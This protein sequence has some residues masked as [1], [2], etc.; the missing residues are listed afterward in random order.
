MRLKFLLKKIL[1]ATL[2]ILTLFNFI[3][4]T[5]VRSNLSFADVDDSTT[6]AMAVSENANNKTLDLIEGAASGIATLVTLGIKMLIMGLV[7]AIQGIITAL[8]ASA[9]VNE[10][11]TGFI[12]PFDIFFNKFKLVDI[13]IFS[14]SGL[15]TD[16]LVYKIRTRTSMWYYIFRAIALVI[17]AIML[18]INLVK[19]LSKNVSSDQKANAKNS[20]ID[21]LTSLVLV[22]FMHIIVIAIINLNNV[23]VDMIKNIFNTSLASTGLSDIMDAILDT[24]FSWN[25]ILSW[26]SVA[27]YAIMVFQ[28]GR[29]LLVYI[30]RFLIVELLVIIS[31]FI[32]ITYSYDKMK[33]GTGK[34]LN[35]WISEMIYNV[36][37]QL[38]H[39]IIYAVMVG[40]AMESLSSSSGIGSL[41]DLAPAVM[42]IATMFFIKQAEKML[43]SIF[44][45]DKAQSIT[46][47]VFENSFNSVR[48]AV[49]TI[50]RFS[51]AGA[52][53]A[54]G[55]GLPFGQNIA[56]T[57]RANGG[58]EGTSRLG[59]FVNNIRA[60]RNAGAQMRNIRN[61]AGNDALN[62]EFE[63]IQGDRSSSSN[64]N[65]SRALSSASEQSLSGDSSSSG[66]ARETAVAAGGGFLGGMMVGG[67]GSL[68]EK[69]DEK[70]RKI[71]DTI[72]STKTK[73]T[74]HTHEKEEVEKPVQAD[75]YEDISNKEIL[76]DFRIKFQNIENQAKDIENEF[77]AERENKSNELIANLQ[78]RGQSL[79]PDVIKDIQA[80]IDGES[81]PNKINAYINNLGDTPERRYADFYNTLKQNDEFSSELQEQKKALISEYKAKGI[82]I[83]SEMEKKL[84]SSNSE[85]AFDDLAKK[86]TEKFV[87]E[88]EPTIT[89]V[90]SPETEESVDLAEIVRDIPQVR[91][92]AV[93]T[94]ARI[95]QIH[96][97][98]E[99]DGSINEETIT[100]ITIETSKALSTNQFSSSNIESAKAALEKEGDEAVRAFKEYSENPNEFTAKA[101]SNAGRELA[102][103][104]TRAQFAGFMVTQAQ[105]IQ[106]ESSSYEAQ[107]TKTS[108]VT[109]GVLNDLNRRRGG[110]NGIID[111][112]AAIEARNRNRNNNSNR[113][114]A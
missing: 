19:A 46:N 62:A 71:Q 41:G 109:S 14:T 99:I 72:D 64:L 89:V 69:V 38:L 11:L 30:K 43:K 80:V 73:E 105:T 21:W 13:N 34:A 24:C 66:S 2:I 83:D 61:Q 31:P 78:K 86:L 29:F 77:K 56:G 55:S 107:T 113:K 81:D 35:G 44:G 42:A 68:G 51:N 12:T 40:A 90:K 26:A 1:V 18:V 53:M 37:L 98:A 45:F 104:Q 94:L 25:F 79:D 96:G 112:T 103:L 7:G 114:N 27:V 59:Q 52:G 23:F 93:Q 85:E 102:E 88:T 111:V 97:R 87:S 100:D 60:S 33:G 47:S 15:S 28:T 50:S 63:P 108:S 67:Q 32:P 9:G 95:N 92:A 65:N 106:S 110:N 57:A 16:S 82:D 48:N 75:S 6:A 39:A 10:A 58:A 36:F 4:A 91:D 8:A 49:G 74:I 76:E 70:F 5:G 84:L 17:I 22:M 101:L 54:A 20:I 3:Y